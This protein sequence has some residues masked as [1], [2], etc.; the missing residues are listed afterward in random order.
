VREDVTESSQCRQVTTELVEL[1]VNSESLRQSIN[2]L[3]H[4]VNVRKLLQ[5]LCC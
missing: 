5:I 1:R 2:E 4:T 3:R